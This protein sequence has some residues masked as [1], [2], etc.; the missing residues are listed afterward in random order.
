MVDGGGIVDRQA[1]PMD[2]LFHLRQRL[3]QMDV[4]A[5]DAASFPLR[6][7][8]LSGGAS[9]RMGRD[10][11]LMPHPGGGCWLDH[12]LELLTGLGVPITVLSRHPRHLTLAM[13]WGRGRRASEAFPSAS[14]TTLPSST[15]SLITAIA[16]PPPWEGPLL[17]LQRLMDHHPNQR[18]LLCPVDMPDLNLV[19]LRI[20]VAAASMEP[21]AIHL[22]HDGQRLQPLLGHYPADALRRRQLSDAVARGERRLQGWLSSQSCRW[23]VLDRSALRNVNRPQDL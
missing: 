17:A 11:A 4:A 3:L 21:A 19:S 18:L 13:A 9:R 7:C 20:L 6:C 16:E 22:A 10:K 8:L 23:V 1:D 5:Q 14:P 12:T 15:S 2:P